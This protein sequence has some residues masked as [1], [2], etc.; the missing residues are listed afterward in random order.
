[1]FDTHNFA[2]HCGGRHRE[3]KGF[4]GRHGGFGDFAGRFERGFGAGRD[5]L[6]DNGEL[7]MVFLHFIA[8]KPS[9]GYELIK[10]I[11]ERLAGAYA[12]SPGVVYPTLTMLEE[13]GY[14]TVSAAEGGKKLYAASE[15]GLEYLKANQ[16]AVKAILARMEQSGH[17]FGRGRS[18]QIVRAMMN[19]GFAVKMRAGQGDLTPERI[20]KIAA[21][22]DLAART[23]DEV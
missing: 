23:I 8:Q 20:A 22:I 7:R 10:D 19:L 4:R 18:P 15:R 13:E 11:E 9:Y 5:R 14:A 1:M 21:A 6:F 3:E 16:V 17:A 12:P 2:E